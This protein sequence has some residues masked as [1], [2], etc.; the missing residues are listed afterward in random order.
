MFRHSSNVI[1]KYIHYFYKKIFII[2][3]VIVILFIITGV[4]TTTKP[5]SR[6]SSSIFASW[7]GNI[8]SSLF[9][10]LFSMENNTFYLFYSG[11]NNRPKFS[12]SIFNFLTSIK[13]TDMKSFLSY[14]I[15]GFSTYENKIIIAGEGIGDITNY[16]DESGPPLENVLQERKAIA[17]SEKET[18]SKKTEQ[19]EEPALTTDGRK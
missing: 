12:E 2:I 16:V 17:D 10:Q 9:L 13:I 19:K 4:L 14:E 3:I 8:E 7:T 15:P 6:L 18:D 5:S 1:L 11:E